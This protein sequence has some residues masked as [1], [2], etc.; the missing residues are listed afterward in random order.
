MTWQIAL[1]GLWRASWQGGVVAVGILLIRAILGRRLAPQWRSRLWL[2]VAIR[3]ALPMMPSSAVSVFNLFRTSPAETPSQMH[4]FNLVL[5]ASRSLASSPVKSIA[6][7]TTPTLNW[8]AVAGIVW[9]SGA[10][11]LSARLLMANIR[12]ARRVRRSSMQPG[13][14]LAAILNSMHS[15]RLPKLLVT[16]AVTS[17]AI[18]GLFRPAL[19]VPSEFSDQVN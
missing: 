4:Q 17:P 9:L 16:P 11:L 15:N 3:F 1:S 13:D 2:L 8:L 14:S 12:F 19:L 5:G 6:T 18:Y 10:L 7:N